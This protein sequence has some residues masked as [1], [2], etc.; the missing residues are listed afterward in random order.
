MTF[1]HLPS[2][3]LEIIIQLSLPEGFESLSVTCKRVHAACV[4]FIQRHNAL[5]SRFRHFTYYDSSPRTPLT[6][7]SAI[8]LIK[9]IAVEPAIARSLDTPTSDTIA[10]DGSFKISLY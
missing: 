9:R 8:T 4:P 10:R 7:M 3:L 1:A 5:R 6:I 2:E